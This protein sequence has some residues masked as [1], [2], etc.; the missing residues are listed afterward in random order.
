MTTARGAAAI[1][2]RIFGYFAFHGTT[3]SLGIEMERSTKY[4][5]RSAP[6]RRTDPRGGGA[7]ERPPGREGF[8]AMD[9]VAGACVTDAKKGAMR[10][11]T[12]R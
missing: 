8:S 4:L 6:D 7:R 2:A 12:G 9:D 5:R 1:R 10:V 11:F 3:V